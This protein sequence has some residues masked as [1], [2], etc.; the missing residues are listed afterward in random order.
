MAYYLLDPF[1]S[2]TIDFPHANIR[3]RICLST[4]F[5]GTQYIR[6]NLFVILNV[7]YDPSRESIGINFANYIK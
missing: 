4:A 5:D 1:S 6:E 7:S 3:T 2:L